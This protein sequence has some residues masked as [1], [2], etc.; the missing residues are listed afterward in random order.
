MSRRNGK[1]CRGQRTE[2]GV[3]KN[4]VQFLRAGHVAR[5]GYGHGLR[6]FVQKPMPTNLPPSKN[7]MQGVMFIAVSTE[8]EHF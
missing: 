8:T 1:A 6:C 5:H 7:G 4:D 3:K 2:I